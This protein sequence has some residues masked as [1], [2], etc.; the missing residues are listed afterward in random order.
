VITHEF[1]II[2]PPQRYV[3]SIEIETAQPHVAVP[4]FSP[5]TIRLVET[6]LV[7]HPHATC[8]LHE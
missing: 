2:D 8:G 5:P 1:D 7:E 6:G 3:S 4:A